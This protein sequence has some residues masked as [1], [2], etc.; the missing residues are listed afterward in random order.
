MLDEKGPDWQV[1][2]ERRWAM[3]DGRG[4]SDPDG[5]IGAY[6]WRQISGQTVR[7]YNAAGQVGFIRAPRLRGELYKVLLFELEVTDD[8]GGR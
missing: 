7:I 2:R 3:M 5:S 6:R 8:P 1:D 4:S